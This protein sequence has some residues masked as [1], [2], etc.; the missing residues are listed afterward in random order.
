MNFRKMNAG[1]KTSCVWTAT[2][3]REHALK[4]VHRDTYN[5]VS[6]IISKLDDGSPHWG[7]CRRCVSPTCIRQVS[8]VMKE[9]SLYDKKKGKGRIIKSNERMNQFS[10]CVTD[11]GLRTQW[12]GHRLIHGHRRIDQTL[13][14]V[15]RPCR[16]DDT[17]KFCARLL[18]PVPP[19]FIGEWKA[20]NGYEI[21]L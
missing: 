20:K 14:Q 13:W 19:Q 11:Y 18:F 21:T 6:S 5:L 9:D 7:L 1:R 15:L 17:T 10:G 16:C 8:F 3:L 2:A 12:W 4:N